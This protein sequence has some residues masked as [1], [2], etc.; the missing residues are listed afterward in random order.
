MIIKFSLKILHKEK[1][2]LFLP[3]SSILLTSCVVVLSYFLISSTSVYLSKRDKEFIGGDVSIESSKNFDINTY[4]PESEIKN[5]SSQINFQGLI[6]RNDNATGV[7]FTFVDKNF[8]LYG[9]LVLKSG[10]Y[11]YP[12]DND[13]YVDENLEQ[14]LNLKIG[15]NLKFNDRIFLVKG[16]VT[17]NPE[18]LLSGFSFSPK[19]ILAQEAITYS[20]IDLE[21]FKKEYRTKAIVKNEL[22]KDAKNSLREL[23]RKNGAR[24]NF[25]GGG[26]SGVQFALELV[27]NFLLVVILVIIILALVNIYSSVSFLAERLRRSFAI[28]MSLGSRTRDIYKILIFVN[29][30]VI[31][32]AILFGTILAC[33]LNSWIISIVKNNFQINLRHDFDLTQTI[34]IFLL[35]YATSLIATL[36]VMNKLKS[37]SPK[38]LLINAKNKESNIYRNIFKDILLGIF[39]VTLISIYFLDSFFYGILIVGLIIITYALVMLFYS[40]IIGALYKIRAVFPFVIKLLITQK[41]FDGFL[42]LVT[43]VSLFVALAAVFNLSLLRTAI[44][45]YLR[46]DLREN[47]PSVYVLDLQKSQIENFKNLYPDST[48]FP[49][50]RSRL[51][52]I[53]GLDIQKELEKEKPKLDREFG[54]EFNLTYRNNLIGG[55]EVVEGNFEKIKKGEVSLEQD[56]AK[57][58]GAKL[59]SIIIVN[60]QGISLETKVTSIRKVDTRSGLPFF[61]LVFSPED[62]KQYPNT[63]FGYLNIPS[64][65]IG[66]V[67]KKLASDFPNVSLIDTGKISRIAED[68]IGLLLVIILIITIPPIVLSTLLIINIIIIMSKDRKRDGARLVALGKTKKYLRNFFIFESIITLLLSSLAAYVFALLVANFLVIKFIEIKKMVYFD[69][70]SFYIFI[71]LLCA[72]L[73]VSFF[74]WAKGTGSIRDNLNYEDNN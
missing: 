58:L 36:P 37:L 3:F 38:E 51:I 24:A 5:L 23:A 27:K 59:G 52:S 48:L 54:R 10:V 50:V 15:D 6:S 43:F 71:S 4:F 2:K 68:V 65:D 41:K 61:F 62:L 74:V 47:I 7:N 72:I 39:P 20:Q 9:N 70:V 73:I 19:V 46:E 13:I 42:G 44:D 28:L 56:F 12:N 29:S 17:Q 30:F 8:P 21:L 49:N 55:E 16:I 57:R 63:S 35:I 34:L 60:I 26:E 25:E 66:D 33:V 31:L 32:A 18:S 64:G 11:D 40:Y 67:S 69:L 45:Q 14:S 53:D 22:T 1:E